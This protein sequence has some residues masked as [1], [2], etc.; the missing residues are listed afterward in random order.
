MNSCN[1]VL[2]SLQQL[3]YKQ[4]IYVLVSTL[5]QVSASPPAILCLHAIAATTSEPENV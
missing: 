5:K 3:L 1:L 2:R 4:N